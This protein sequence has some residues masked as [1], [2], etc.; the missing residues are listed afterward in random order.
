M[1]ATPTK[2]QVYRCPVCG[3]ELSV[4]AGRTGD[5]APVCCDRP[6][7]RLP[8]RLA[9]YVCPVCGAEI[10]VVRAGEGSFLPRCCDT[11]MR[12]AAA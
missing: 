12:L 7:E 6:M 1:T 4:L 10:G 11:D 8:R 2:G 3:A 5:F 9:F